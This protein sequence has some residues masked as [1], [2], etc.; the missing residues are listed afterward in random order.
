MLVQFWALRFS[1]VYEIGQ[2]GGISG[3]GYEY[4]RCF[5]CLVLGVSIFCR[6]CDWTNENQWAGVCIYKVL[7]L[8]SSSDHCDFLSYI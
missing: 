1:I 7:C 6:I 5:V 8:F 4:I 2:R 3:L